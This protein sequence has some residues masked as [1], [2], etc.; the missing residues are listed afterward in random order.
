MPGATSHLG[1]GEA[2]NLSRSACAVRGERTPCRESTMT[3][4]RWASGAAACARAS[5]AGGNMQKRPRTRGAERRSRD[6]ERKVNMDHRI[7]G[8]RDKSVS[9]RIRERVDSERLP[10]AIRSAPGCVLRATPKNTWTVGEWKRILGG[11]TSH[12]KLKKEELCEKKG[13]IGALEREPGL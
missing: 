4:S 11:I 6:A 13:A 9:G 3:S 12:F 1:Q 8:Y 2:E 5:C 10:K 7:R